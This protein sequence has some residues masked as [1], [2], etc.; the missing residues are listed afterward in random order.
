VG[1]SVVP[2]RPAIRYYAKALAKPFAQ[3]FSISLLSGLFWMV[4]TSIL[5]K[6]ILKKMCAKKRQRLEAFSEESEFKE[7]DILAKIK[8][9]AGAKYDTSLEVVAKTICKYPDFSCS[10]SS[11][12]L[13]QFLEKWT[14][15]FIKGFE[16][17][18]SKRKGKVMGTAS[19]EV[20]NQIIQSRITAL[21][22]D[23]IEQIKFAHRLSMSAENIAGALL[24]EYLAAN[25]AVFGWYCCW[26]ETMKSIDFVNKDGR[27][28]QVKNSDN[29]EN[30]SS[31]TV[32]DGTKIEHW[33]RR[34]SRKG[35][36]NW[37]KLNE[38]IGIKDENKKLSEE[39][40]KKFIKYII[41]QN[42]DCLFVEE[43]NVWLDLDTDS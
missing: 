21:T 3:H 34:F 22:D 32:R 11:E 43:D 13:S 39:G 29:S 14:A 37:D 17:R 42:P 2:F 6:Q 31:K 10:I 41:A 5:S 9:V 23:Q 15:K 12:S 27:L 8:E 28:L 24:E 19:D 1:S 20:I 30:S 38:L 35:T 7:V 25:L 36:T 40:F 18:S 16:N 26:G 4:G 33:F